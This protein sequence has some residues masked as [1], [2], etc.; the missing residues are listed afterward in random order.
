M[1]LDVHVK[2][3][4]LCICL[5]AR[6]AYRVGFVHMLFHWSFEDIHYASPEERERKKTVSRFS[7][8]VR[9]AMYSFSN[10]LLFKI[11]LLSGSV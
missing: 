8:K 5:V 10:V 6:V 9:K 11:P 2:L 1:C 7:S 4:V 3:L